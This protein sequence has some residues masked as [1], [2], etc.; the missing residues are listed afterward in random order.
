[1]T[2][3]LM[4]ALALL[5]GAMP[6]RHFEVDDRGPERLWIL[7]FTPAGAD[8]SVAYLEDALPAFL[9]VAI[10]GS[11]GIHSIVER[12]RMNAV[13]AEQSLS[14]EHLTSAAT[15]QRVGKLLGATVTISG[16]FV[17]LG[18]ELLV[19]LRAADLESGI[20][21]A[22]TEGRGPLGQPA[23][24]VTSL[25]RTLS[26]NL[27][28]RLPALAATQIDH[29]PLANLHF[30][31]G[32][33][34]YYAARYSHALGE[35]MLA[36]DEPRLTSIGRY[37]QANAYLAQHQYSSGCLELARLKRASPPEIPSSDVDVKLRT[38][39]RYLSADDLQL[40]RDLAARRD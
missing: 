32:L 20:I 8:S 35:F 12:E 23:E 6:L 22:S 19:T 40:I 9:M 18:E 34:H 33:G 2:Q 11:D 36:S 26:G 10:S 29:A 1:M 17:R 39:E 27:S 38:C 7:P 37:W 16:S 28:P 5:L 14:L 13:L 30:L 21:V 4:C 24:L 3:L 31:K 25:Y 15:R